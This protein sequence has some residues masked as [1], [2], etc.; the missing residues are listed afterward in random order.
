MDQL[1]QLFDRK[2]Q[3]YESAFLLSDTVAQ[4]KEQYDP[5]YALPN[6]DHQPRKYRSG[7]RSTVIWQIVLGLSILILNFALTVWSYTALHI[8]NGV[9][10]IYQGPCTTTK[11]VITVLHLAICILSSLLLGASNYCMQLLSAPT[12]KEVDAAH[13]R[14]KWLSIGVISFKNLWYV[15]RSKAFVYFVLAISSIPLHLLWNSAFLDTLASNGYTYS[16]VTEGFLE[17][18]PWNNSKTFLPINGYPD[19]AQAMLDRHTNGTLIRMNNTDCIN[20]YSVEFLSK[21]SNV[22]LVYS[23][24]A[25]I[26][27]VG[28]NSLLLQGLNDGGTTENGVLTSSSQG[29]WICGSDSPCNLGQ[30]A[31]YNDTHWSPWE[32]ID[33][34]IVEANGDPDGNIGGHVRVKGSIEYCLAEKPERPC[35]LGISPPI[36][37]VVLICNVIKVLCFAATLRIGGFMDPL[38]TNGDAIQSFLLQPDTSLKNHCLASRREVEK[39]KEFWSE[40]PLPVMWQGRRNFCALGAPRG[41]WLAAFIP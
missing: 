36:L 10:T 23:N 11:D 40:R 16:A 7:W 33:L 5:S 37:A 6:N 3:P 27:G 32:S 24:S 1:R 25:N 18:A 41:V 35:T 30:I 9:A 31:R 14:H 22:L 20:A 2:A 17:G 29:Q 39:N 34:D 13:A 15:H 21:Y 19:E 12:R 26:N 4:P 28:N 38:L 8:E